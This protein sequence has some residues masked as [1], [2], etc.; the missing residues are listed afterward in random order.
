MFLSLIL[1]TKSWNPTHALYINV[2]NMSECHKIK[3][4]ASY[5]RDTQVAIWHIQCEG[6]IT[7]RPTPAI[8]LKVEAAMASVDINDELVCPLGTPSFPAGAHNYDPKIHDLIKGVSKC[9]ISIQEA[10]AELNEYRC[11][12]V[13][14]ITWWGLHWW[15]GSKWT[16]EWGQQRS[17]TAISRMGAPTKT[18]RQ[19]INKGSSGHVPWIREGGSLSSVLTCRSHYST[20]WN[21]TRLANLGLT[22]LAIETT[23]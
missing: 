7:R 15:H 2:L 1:N 21:N 23:E 11:E 16:R 19:V 20:S 8:G 22:S 13:T 9:M 12:W 10:Q 18:D 4:W 5:K 14:R 3:L 17:S 6:G